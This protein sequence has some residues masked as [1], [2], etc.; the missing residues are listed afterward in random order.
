MYLSS[1]GTTI[2]TG[3]PDSF[4]KMSQVCIQS[5]FTAL[6]ET[7]NFSPEVINVFHDDPAVLTCPFMYGN[8]HQYLDPY[9]ISWTLREGESSTIILDR[10]ESLHLSSDQ[11]E[12][13]IAPEF[14]T[15]FGGQYQCRFRL[16]RCTH[17][18][19]DN[20]AL[21]SLRCPEELYYG[22]LTAIQQ[23]GTFMHHEQNVVFHE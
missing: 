8:L 3:C 13:R 11:R 5:S 12:F 9:E 4:S 6:P 10:T 20:E 15:V 14:H 18:D 21:D 16:G 17:F 23:F 1:H 19:E 7:T 22:S 2:Y